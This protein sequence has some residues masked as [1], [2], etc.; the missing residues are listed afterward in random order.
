MSRYVGKLRELG[1][2]FKKKAKEKGYDKETVT[3]CGGIALCDQNPNDPCDTFQA[4]IK[5]LDVCE[6][7]P[8]LLTEAM[9]LIGIEDA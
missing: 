9:G 4:L 2:E 5:L 7:E 8:T 1:E 6:D 3:I